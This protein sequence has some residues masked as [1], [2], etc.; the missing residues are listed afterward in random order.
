MSSA[1]RMIYIW[2]E[3]EEFYSNLKNKSDFINRKLS[4]ERKLLESQTI[5]ADRSQ[6]P[7]PR[8]RDLNARVKAMDDKNRKG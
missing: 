5:P 4:E 1:K 3:N 7:D 6:H 8:M 2:P